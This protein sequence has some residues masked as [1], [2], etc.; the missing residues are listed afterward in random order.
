LLLLLLLLLMMLLVLIITVLARS[1]PLPTIQTIRIGACLFFSFCGS[2]S[3]V[4]S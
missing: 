4:F 2:L 1:I 3:P